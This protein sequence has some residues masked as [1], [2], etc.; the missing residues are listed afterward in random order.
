MLPKSR[1]SIWSAICGSKK[2]TAVRHPMP[3]PVTRQLGAVVISRE[4]YLRRLALAVKLVREFLTSHVFT[5]NHGQ[6]CI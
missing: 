3:T 5:R 6:S 4:E 1:W 2:F